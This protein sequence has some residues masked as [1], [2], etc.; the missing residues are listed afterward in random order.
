[1]CSAA[2]WSTVVAPGSGCL[3]QQ[4]FQPGATVC[5]NRLMQRLHGSR[6]ATGPLVLDI[7][8]YTVRGHESSGGHAGGSS[9]HGDAGASHMSY[10]LCHGQP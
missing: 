2:Q 3:R 5:Q 4:D 1:M 7:G 6:S 10:R 8:N 9:M